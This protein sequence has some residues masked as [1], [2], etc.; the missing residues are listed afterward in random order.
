MSH[1]IAVYS[2]ST[3][4][5]WSAVVIFLGLAAALFMTL[6]LHRTNGGS[7]FVVWLFMPLTIVLGVVLSRALHWYCHVEQYGRLL[8]ALR[9]YSSGS[10]VI[11]GALLGTWLAAFVASQMDVGS[12][13][14][15]LD[16][17]APGAAL[18]VAFIR[19][20]ALFNSSCRSKILIT[21]PFLQHLP[22][23]SGLPN[24]AGQ[25]EYRFA[26]FFIHFLLM[27][28][29]CWWLLRFFYTR[30]DI[31]MRSGS[32]D[33]NVFR[34]FLLLYSAG[35]FIIDS[36]RYDSSFFPF[37]GFVSVVQIF[38]GVCI[39]GVLIYYSV[40]SVRAWGLKLFHW[41]IWVGW[42]LAAGATGYTEYLV[43]RHGDWYLGCYGAMALECICMSVLVY[44]MYLSCCN[45]RKARQP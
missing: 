9:D 30:R 43:Q 1:P 32:R 20:S 36:T 10:Y 5:Y 42:L 18:S 29:L 27:L 19:L 2:G 33:G 14:K 7:A 44:R 25:I 4:L 26:T 39:L 23:A 24:S 6:S 21:S 15:L 35:E 38:A 34:I 11:T 45:S 28:L 13:A 8:N 3:V 16:A 12:T 37:N 17:F 22:L 40:H 41:L 31:P